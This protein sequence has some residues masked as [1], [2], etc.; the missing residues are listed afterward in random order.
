MQ[1][2]V[3]KKELLQYF[4]SSTLGGHF[5]VNATMR[6][7]VEVIYW[8]GMKKHVREFVKECQ[9]C[10]CNKYET[11]AS[12]GLL[13]PLP[14]PQTVWSEISMDFIEGLPKSQ[15]KDVIL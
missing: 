6:R 14:L 8:K 9:T 11:V 4:H 5:G 2:Q 10:Q 13:Q 7:L 15:G 1:T 12:P 3:L